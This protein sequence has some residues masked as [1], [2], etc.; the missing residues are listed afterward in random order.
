MIVDNI[1]NFENY[2]ALNPKFEVAFDFIKKAALKKIV[3]K[4]KV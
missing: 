3:V 4:V 2:I 1:K